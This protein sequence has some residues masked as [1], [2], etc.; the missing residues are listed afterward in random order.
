MRKMPRLR[1]M[2]RKFSSKIKR[3]LT[4]ICENIQHQFIPTIQLIFYHFSILSI[5]ILF[6]YPKVQ[7]ND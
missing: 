1:M 2:A 6:A 3:Q 4:I 7:V 5:F